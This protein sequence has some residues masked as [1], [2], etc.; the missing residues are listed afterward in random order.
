MCCS[1]VYQQHCSTSDIGQTSSQ[2]Q[3]QSASPQATTIDVLSYP[4]PTEQSLH[5]ARTLLDPPLPEPI[6]AYLLDLVFSPA[7]NLGFLEIFRY[8]DNDN[9]NSSSSKRIKLSSPV[10]S[11]P[12]SLL[13]ALIVVGATLSSTYDPSINVSTLQQYALT[14]TE[15]LYGT[16]R[17]LQIDD[18]LALCF[19][20]HTG[21]FS[22]DSL[23]VAER[24][25]MLASTIARQVQD[26]EDY[27][28]GWSYQQRARWIVQINDRFVAPLP[29]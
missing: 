10:A 19:L 6:V 14:A 28:I 12:Q 8:H 23:K 25:A 5:L 20:S 15:G 9:T 11:P 7:S 29:L 21:C 22:N 16:S 2:T 13:A 1:L 18:A 24:W 4:P 27:E 3:S 17:E 26:I